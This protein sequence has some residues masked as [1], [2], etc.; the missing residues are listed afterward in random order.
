M[1]DRRASGGPIDPDN[2]SDETAMRKRMDAERAQQDQMTGLAEPLTREQEKV[3]ARG[4]PIDRKF[5]FRHN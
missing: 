1:T 3:I 5:K 4:G 2:W